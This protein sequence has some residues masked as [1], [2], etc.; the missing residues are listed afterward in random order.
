MSAAVSSRSPQA[1][2][3]AP[4][5]S[6][7]PM[8]ASKKKANKP[9]RK[10]ITLFFLR[11]L[12]ALLPLV[13][14]MFVFVT[15]IN[16]VRNY[17]TSPINNTIYWSLESNG[18]GWN[19]LDRLSIDP[20][21]PRFLNRAEILAE[22]TSLSTGLEKYGSTS[23]E[24]LT[25][26][27]AR[28]QAIAENKAAESTGIDYS[29]VIESMAAQSPMKRIAEPDE[30]ANAIAFLASPAASYINGINVPVDGGRTKS[31]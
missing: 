13:L 3:H 17:V 29:E 16:F 20:Y 5:E 27:G 24:F 8:S 7:A 4:L 19:V 11:G 28:L 21:D 2:R 18:L 1:T 9:P 22:P 26:L 6:F 14:T 23:T 12:G 15:L 25:E 30:I 31:L 10:S